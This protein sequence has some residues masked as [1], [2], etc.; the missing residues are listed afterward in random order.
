MNLNKISKLFHISTTSNKQ[1]TAADVVL[2]SHMYMDNNLVL[3][4]LVNFQ[5]LN[6]TRLRSGMEYIQHYA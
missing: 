4:Y 1:E 2:S 3:D 5:N 6:P